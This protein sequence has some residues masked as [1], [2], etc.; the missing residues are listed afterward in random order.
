MFP[1]CSKNGTIIPLA[2]AVMPVTH[3]EFAYGFGVYENIRVVRGTP[4]FID[5]HLARLETS[6]RVIG[7]VHAFT[8]TDIKQWIMALINECASDALNLKILLVGG[9]EPHDA[10]LFILPL[11]P[12]FPDK[13]LYRDG[14]TA[15]TVRYERSF[16]DAKTLSM[17]GS[18]VAYRKAK[19]EGAYDAL[20]IDHHGNITEGTRTNFF[21][22]KDRTIIS[23]PIE[24]IL[25]GVTMKHVLTVAK[26]NGFTVEERDIRPQ[27]LPS[28]DGAFFTSTSSKIMPIRLIDTMIL[29]ISKDLKELMEHYSDF[30]D[31]TMAK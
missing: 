22:I 1:L 3:I 26:N 8:S 11:A 29:P 18:Y 17:L 10:T 15:I 31:Q 13:K 7:L 4:L 20:L 16:P 19:A 27:D 9:R 14:V 25:E 24:K 5:D 2:D 30:L 6:A 23:A 21:C 28:F 12:L